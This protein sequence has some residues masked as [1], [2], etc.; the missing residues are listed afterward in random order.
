MS[1]HGGFNP[2][3]DARGRYA[4]QP[5][6]AQASARIEGQPLPGKTEW[7]K[8]GVRV[9]FTGGRKPA[10]RVM[11]GDVL[12]EEI[13]ATNKWKQ[14]LERATENAQ[15]Y[16]V[17]LQTGSA[18]QVVRQIAAEQ[19]GGGFEYEMQGL[20]AAAKAAPSDYKAVL[21]VGERVM[22]EIDKELAVV[23]ARSHL[24]NI[25]RHYARAIAESNPIAISAG[26]AELA[27]A[28]WQLVSAIGRAAGELLERRRTPA[29]LDDIGLDPVTS[30]RAQDLVEE[31]AGFLPRAMVR[32]ASRNAVG[33]YR[34][35]PALRVEEQDSVRAY[36]SNSHLAMVISRQDGR[37]VVAHEL[38]HWLEN[39]VP[40]MRSAASAYLR[41]RTA[42]EEPRRLRE[43]V[44][45]WYDDHEVAKPDRF[46]NPYMG[47]IYDTGN[48]ELVSMLF[49]DYTEN[50][51]ETAVKDLEAYTWFLG[52]LHSL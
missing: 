32:A 27:R 46:V 7:E 35:R 4:D 24:A 42:G 31:V 18:N 3:R 34:S 38:G 40:G 23:T 17:E 1:A 30:M 41:A 14:E 12:I 47:K 16:L 19:R 49:E 25:E 48:T 5:G 37:R 9:E 2:F 45:S 10:Y 51:H 8:D 20:T 11:H 6:L 36:Y 29:T 21:K 44:G 52:V 22:A 43:L 15:K 26:V 33:N 50:N 28:R 13:P 39:N